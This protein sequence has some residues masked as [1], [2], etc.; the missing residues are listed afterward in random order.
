MTIKTQLAKLP[1]LYNCFLNPYRDARFGRCPQCNNKTGQKKVPLVI[2]V[3][4]HYPLI[5]NDTCRYCANCDLLIAHKDKIEGYLAQMFSQRIPEAMGNDYLVIGTAEKE[6]WRD[7]LENPHPPTDLLDNLHGFKEYRNYTFSGGW[8]TDEDYK[9]A[10][11]GKLPSR[12]IEN[13][14]NP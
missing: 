3:D 2:H 13:S 12:N 1:P 14:R 5:F 11:Q 4:P 10:L 8:M 9:K 7:G 6:Y